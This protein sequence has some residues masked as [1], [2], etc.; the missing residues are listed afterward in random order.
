MTVTNAAT[1]FFEHFNSRGDRLSIL[2]NYIEL[3]TIDLVLALGIMGIA[4]ALSSWQ[5]LALEGQLFFA[6]GRSLLQLM[7]VGYILEFVFA[8]DN[9]L[10]V[11]VILGIMLTIAAIVA[12][13]RIGKQIGLLPVVW[14]SLFASAALTL[15]YTM[16]LIIRPPNWY[17]PQY[18]IPL[19][20][21]ILGNGLNTASLCGERLVSKIKSSPLEIETHL[22]LGA[23]PKQAISAYRTEAIRTGLIPTINSMMVVGM[24]SLPGMFTGQVLAGSDPLNAASYQILILFVIALTNLTTALLITEGVYRQF[25]NRQSQLIL[26]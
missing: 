12:R 15:S 23:T 24:V 5:K 9:P 16:V 10:A 21:M 18:L 14:G 7:V 11:L 2:D 26:R 22:S 4:I 19:A 17:E 13:N 25:F 8:V 6:T 3:D 20:G 1:V